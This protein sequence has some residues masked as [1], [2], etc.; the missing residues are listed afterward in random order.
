MEKKN[1]LIVIALVG[2]G[3]VLLVGAFLTL[4]KTKNLPGTISLP[5]SK[6]ETTQETIQTV[7]LDKNGFNPASII[8]K[9][10][11]RVIWINK[12][13]KT[14][15]VN[16]DPH[17]IHNLYPMLQLG[18]FENGSSVQAVFNNAGT[19]TYHNHLAPAQKGTVV[20]Q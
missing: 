12:S 14:A 1:N 19:Y 13:G 6:P 5:A 9:R 7:T 8:I 16:S 11:T 4:G 17:P 15:T 18:N 10:G 2:I 20:V 3:V